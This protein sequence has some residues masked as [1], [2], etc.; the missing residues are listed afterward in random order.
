MEKVEYDS[1]GRMTYNPSYHTSHRKPFTLDD[2]IYMCRFIDYDGIKSI[3]LALGK[4]E[5]TV[6]SK[7]ST[8]R[9][10]GQFYR[11]KDLTLEEWEKIVGEVSK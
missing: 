6:A 5:K 10:T 1:R 3:S 4:T 11:Y 7:L 8:L 9:K 2:L